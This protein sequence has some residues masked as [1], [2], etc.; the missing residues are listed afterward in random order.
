MAK[1][2]VLPIVFVLTLLSICFTFSES[3]AAA[4]FIVAH[5]RVSQKKLNQNM[6]R[7]SVS[8]DIYNSGSDTAYDVTLTDDSWAQEVFDIV[9]GNTSKSWERLDTG[10]LVS[11]SFELLSSVK[12]VYYGAPALI[13]Y[14]IP[15]KSKLQEAYSTPIMP[16]K[17]LSEAASETKINLVSL[18]LANY[19]SHVSV[20]LV[21]FLFVS[22]MVSKPNA[23]KGSK[24]KR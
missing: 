14:R 19:G 10:A 22:L 9:T 24:K 17:I 7:V 3:A 18:L 12:T 2:L 5:K 11:H 6:E 13:T 1:T 20:V 23:A 15:M 21:V 4:P 8:I 16:L